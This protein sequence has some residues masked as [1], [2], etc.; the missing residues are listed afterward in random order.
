MSR[1][2]YKKYR[3]GPRGQDPSHV[4]NY[5]DGV[6]AQSVL[7]WSDETIGREIFRN[8]LRRGQDVY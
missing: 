7:K 2:N 8:D 1:H 5:P 4:S 6:I 3:D